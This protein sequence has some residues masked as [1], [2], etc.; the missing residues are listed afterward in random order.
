[1]LMDGYSPDTHISKGTPYPSWFITPAVDTL[2]LHTG[3]N[4][5]GAVSNPYRSIHIR[6][7]HEKKTI[8]V[9]STLP[10]LRLERF[11]LLW[12]EIRCQH[13]VF[14]PFLHKPLRPPTRN[15]LDPARTDLTKFAY[16]LAY[17]YLLAAQWCF[18]FSHQCHR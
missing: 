11:V 9:V 12:R 16:H 6:F 10:E 5:S 14:R 3:C 13:R 8:L 1:M 7:N 4:N 15:Y 17:P 2:L 18:S